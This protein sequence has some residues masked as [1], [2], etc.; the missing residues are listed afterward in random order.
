MRLDSPRALTL[1]VVLALALLAALAAAGYAALAYVINNQLV[2]IDF[3]RAGGRQGMF[4]QRIAML[5]T[6]LLQSLPA[7]SRDEDRKSLLE[8]IVKMDQTEQALTKTDPCM[9]E[10]IDHSSTLRNLFYEQPA[11]LDLNTARFLAA[12]RQIAQ[13]PH[14]GLAPGN[15][16][17]ATVRRL[18]DQLLPSFVA[19]A[20]QAQVQRETEKQRLL[21]LETALFGA[22]LLALILEALFI[23][24]PM[25]RLIVRETRNLTASERQL[26]TVFNTVGEAIFS[27]DDQGRILSLNNEAVRLWS[28]EASSLIGQNLD[29]LFVEP[30]FFAEAVA[31]CSNQTTITYVEAEAITRTGRRFDAEVALDYAQ[32]DDRTLYTLAGRDITDRRQNEK[33]LNEAKDMA[34]MG[35]RAKSEFLANMSHEIRTPLNGVI[36]MTGLLMETELSPTQHDYVDTI[37]ASGESLMTIINDILDFSK[38]EAGHFSLSDAPFDLRACVESALDVLGP[39]AME[40]HLDLTCYVADE[41]PGLV[42]GDEQRLRQVLINLVG[43]AVKFTAKGDVYVEVDAQ[44]VSPAQDGPPGPHAALDQ[45]DLWELTF[46][47][48]DSGIGIPHDKMDRLFKI[49]S[50][51]DATN[52][53]SFGGTGL[54]LAISKR[55]VEL[56]GGSI[57]VTSE[58]G[59]GSIFLF[60]IRVPTAPGQRKSITEAVGSQ[61]RGRRLLVVEDSD[62]SRELLGHH[63]RRWGME[64][65]ECA[66]GPEAIKIVQTGAAFDAAVIDMLMPEMHGLDVATDLRR[67]PATVDIPLI[68]LRSSSADEADPRLKNLSWVSILPKPWKPATLQREITRVLDQREVSACIV[69]P[70]RMLNPNMAEIA[71]VEILVVEDNPTN[72]QVVL[73]VLRALGYQPDMAENGRTGIDKASSHRYDI[74]LLDLQMPDID[75]FEVARHIRQHLNYQPVIVALTAGASPEDRQRCLDAGMDD[76][77]LKPFKISLLKDVVLKYARRSSRRP[78]N[79]PSMP[80]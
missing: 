8:T 53:R 39:R 20:Q 9:V 25:V 50:Q 65:T 3:I 29:H 14:G 5:S 54:G 18:A 42:L 33:R 61:L 13:A 23:F 68:L 31:H 76:Y 52:S 43:N 17:L 59:Q 79:L 63:A 15:P 51:V 22:L 26:M 35:N 24:R 62:V 78:A 48:R 60:T 4:S 1:R 28:Y 47:V 64:V 73:M 69:A 66:S 37:R 58:V 49:F 19:V 45:R 46:R 27:A 10:T 80:I 75:G 41:V 16:D 12:A 7:A 40:K 55:L 6:G 77:V 57:G 32:I 21:W 74:V 2:S 36:G 71:P 72:Q 44:P 34:E 30:G 38:I 67:F 70:T 56:M 11:Q